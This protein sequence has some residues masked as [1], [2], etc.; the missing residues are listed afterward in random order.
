MYVL[1]DS[2]FACHRFFPSFFPYLI[3][4]G[5]YVNLVPDRIACSYST[6]SIPFDMPGFSTGWDKIGCYRALWVCRVAMESLPFT[7]RLSASTF[8]CYGCEVW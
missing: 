4:G 2:R 1:F 3:A 5:F 6:T 7:T 8:V